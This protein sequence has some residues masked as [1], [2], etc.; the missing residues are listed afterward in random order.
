M[1]QTAFLHISGHVSS[2]GWWKEKSWPS[3][4][5]EL[6]SLAGSVYVL[7]V[8]LTLSCNSYEDD[9]RLYDKYERVEA[10]GK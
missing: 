5:E 3:F 1:G 7:A 2:I 9:E 8:I 10:C 6:H 4:K